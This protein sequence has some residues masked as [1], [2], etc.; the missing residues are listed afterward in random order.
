[1]NGN[2]IT[3]EHCTGKFPSVPKPCI[4][5]FILTFTLILGYSDVEC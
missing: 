1:M 4:V 5:I 3:G 2:R